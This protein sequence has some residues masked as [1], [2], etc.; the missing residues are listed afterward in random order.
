MQVFVPLVSNPGTDK[1]FISSP[2]S[3][4]GLW[5]RQSLLS[6]GYRKVFLGGAAARAQT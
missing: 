2:Q 3:Q 1:R 4:N 5:N 6:N